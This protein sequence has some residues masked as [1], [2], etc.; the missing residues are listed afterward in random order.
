MLVFKFNTATSLTELIEGD[1]WAHPEVFVGNPDAVAAT[2]Q[3]LRDAVKIAH[4]SKGKP[5]DPFGYFRDVV[6]GP[7]GWTGLLSFNAPINGNGM[8]ADLQM[9]FA[10][11]DGQLRAHHFGVELPGV[12]AD[13]AG[14]AI[15]ES[16]LFGV[17]HY[18]EPAPAVTGDYGFA[19]EELNVAIAKTTVTEFQAKVAVTINTLFGRSVT[20]QPPSNSPANTLRL[21]GRYQK[22][23]AVGTPDLRATRAGGLR[24][25]RT[26]PSGPGAGPAPGQQRHPDPDRLDPKAGSAADPGSTISTRFSLGGMLSFQADPFPG[27]AGLDLFSYGYQGQGV[28]MSG[29]A[30]TISCEL[31]ADGSRTGPPMIT[32]DLGATSLSDNASAQR[33]GS[34][35]N[36]LP[37]TLDGFLQNAEDGLT[38]SALGATALNVVE[39]APA[40]NPGPD[41]A[42]QQSRQTNAPQYALRFRLPLGS[43]GALSDVHASL[44]AWLVLGK[45]GPSAYTPDDD[46]AGVFVQLPALSAGALGFNLEGLLKTTFGDANL[47]RVPLPAGGAVLWCC[48]TTS[49]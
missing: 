44:D 10:G 16:S 30:L 12:R 11:I 48:S 15:E 46:G 40:S 43:L 25:H 21:T 33:P 14:P 19:V 29:V 18:Q 24:V 42:A 37:L 31:N 23:G 28:G 20:L 41:Q 1:G 38:A 34:L 4:D 27:I 7:P 45:L 32:A 3:C 35:V 5:D 39:L 22:H 26:G 17:I 47:M 2:R 6:A 8:P 9:L 36:L 13:P 49:R